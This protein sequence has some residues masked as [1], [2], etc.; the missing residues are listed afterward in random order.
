MGWMAPVL[1][2]FGA[3][4][5]DK[6][7]TGTVRNAVGKLIVPNAEAEFGLPGRGNGP[8]TMSKIDVNTPPPKGGGFRLRLEAGLIDPSGRSVQTTLKLSSGSSGF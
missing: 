5:F 4:H 6:S 8:S 1:V 2:I 3:D 7:E